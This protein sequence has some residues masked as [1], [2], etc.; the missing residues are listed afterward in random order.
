MKTQSFALYQH[1]LG[2]SFVP[3]MVLE[4]TP[5]LEMG[6]IC[7]VSRRH[8]VVTVRKAKS[9]CF[10]QGFFFLSLSPAA[11]MHGRISSRLRT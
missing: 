2:V 5:W 7:L 6:M 1:F 8:K 9:L 11:L 3:E 4:E 10:V